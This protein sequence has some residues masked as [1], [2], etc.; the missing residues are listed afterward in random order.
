MVMNTGSLP[1]M[2]PL[3]THIAR[4]RCRRA[5]FDALLAQTSPRSGRDRFLLAADVR[6]FWRPDEARAQP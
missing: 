6:W 5:L 2:P 3:T 1:F 4:V